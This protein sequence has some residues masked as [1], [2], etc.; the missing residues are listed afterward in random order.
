MSKKIKFN[1]INANDCQK[2]KI[3]DIQK[4]YSNYINP[5]LTNSLKSFSFGNVLVEKAIGSKIY[6]KNRK[7]ILDF[8]GGLGVLNL[9][10]NPNEILSSRIQFQKKMR[11]EVHK[12][13]FSQY[14]AALSYNL[15]QILPKE[16]SYSYFCNSGAEAVDGAIKMAYKYYNGQRKIILHSDISFHGKLLGSLSISNY[17]E[18]EF[19]FP[20][21]KFGI[22]YKFNNLN[23][24][25]KT[26]KKYKSKIF[27]I[28][29]EPMSASTYKENSKEF[30]KLAKKLS[31]KY[32]I[33]L[34]FDE[35]YT[36][37][38]KSG[39]KFHFNKYNIVPDILIISKSF[40]GGKSSISA[41]STNKDTLL[42]SY[43]NLNDALLHTTTYNGF[44]EE[45]I[46]AIESINIFIKKNLSSKGLK[47]EKKL[48]P[49]FQNLALKYPGKIKEY[50]G[51]GSM[52]GFVLNNKKLDKIKNIQKYFKFSVLKDKKFLDKLLASALLDELFL[53]YGILSTLKF[54]QEVIL[55][56]E[57][58]LVVQNKELDYC[59][60]SINHLFS[61]DFNKILLNFLKNT[62]LRKLI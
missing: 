11:M 22:K 36:G 62:I 9:G 42:K 12:N 40:G 52:H 51:F 5:A 19:K 43:G 17:K 32:N 6:L 23:S 41:Y 55:C 21:I 38:G 2:L 15:A 30:L 31:N 26:V 60:N 59:I 8:T 47:I 39:Y 57:P 24:L 7:K 61:R 29:V 20:K 53:K 45:C 50:R 27:A 1:L 3:K 44:G 14:S 25:E 13:F 18:S 58:S 10:H 46:T 56:V 4:I 48:K 34:I 49:A 16:L 28:I 54:N 35:I 33:K 37:F